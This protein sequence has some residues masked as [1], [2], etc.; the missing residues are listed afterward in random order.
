[1][2][3][4]NL[5]SLERAASMMV[6]WICGVSLKD[7]KESEV[8]YSLLGVKNVTEMVRKRSLKNK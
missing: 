3:A 2:K 5:H 1:M 6:R 8:M 4:E 7:R